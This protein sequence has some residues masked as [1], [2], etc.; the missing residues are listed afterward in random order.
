M[1]NYLTTRQLAD[2]FGVQV[3]DVAYW[4]GTGLVKALPHKP[5]QPWR[6]FPE[7]VARLERDGLPLS[8]RTLMYR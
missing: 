1:S 8:R 7:E 5:G 4:C 3:K 6:I 2:K